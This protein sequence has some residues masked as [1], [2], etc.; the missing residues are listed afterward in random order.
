MKKIALMVAVMALVFVGT[1][2]SAEDS[3]LL[4]EVPTPVVMV[5]PYQ[6]LAQ[7]LADLR[8][9]EMNQNT[10]IFAKFILSFKIRQLENQLNLIK[11]V[12]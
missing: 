12:Q 4:A 1:P 2:V 6:V 11:A 3:A 10:G 7:E 8:I 5:D 9:K